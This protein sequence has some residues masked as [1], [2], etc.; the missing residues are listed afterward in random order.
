MEVLLLDTLKK[1][2][3][4]AKK[5]AIKCAMKGGAPKDG[6]TDRQDNAGHEDT[7]A[8]SSNAVATWIADPCDGT[9]KIVG[10]IRN[11]GRMRP[12]R[13]VR[14]NAQGAQGTNSRL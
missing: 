11:N 14:L 12:V 3:V 10:H 6:A 1:R 13:P 7:D 9:H 5:L 4:T 8:H 2:S